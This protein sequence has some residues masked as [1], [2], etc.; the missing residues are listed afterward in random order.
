MNPQRPN[1]SGS[2]AQGLLALGSL[3]LA[4]GI[5]VWQQ[6]VL[7]RGRTMPIAGA[8]RPT[9]TFADVAGLIEAKE[10]LA[11]I[12]SFLRDPDRFAR[13]G[14]RMPRGVLLAGPP[15]TG[16]TLLARAVAGEARV[17]FFAMSASQ[18]V[19][20]Y[21]GVGA[22]RVRDLF[23]A[24]RKAA[25]AIVFVDELDAIGRRRGDSQ[26]HQEYEQ[27]LNQ[28]LVELDGFHPRQ[29]VVLI[30]ATNRSEILDPALLRPGRFD[31]RVDLNL[32]DRAERAA[33]LKVH[34][35]GKPLDPRVDL[36]GLASRTVGLSG[37]DLEN[38]VNEAALLAV[39]RDGETIHQDD[40]EEAVARVVAGPT[41]RSRTLSER[42][43]NTIAVHEAGH[44]LVA[45]RLSEADAPRRVT[46]LGRGQMG[47]ATMLAPEEDR[48]LWTRGQFLHRLAVLLGG[49]AAEEHRFQEVTTGSSNDLTQ[50]IALART[51]ITGYG[52]GQRLRGLAFGQDTL[53]SEET[54]RAIDDEVKTLVSD[55]LDLAGRTIS[56]DNGT[57]DRLVTALLA[58]ET[59]DENRLAAI[60]GARPSTIVD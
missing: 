54:S 50:A 11:E 41:R 38:T 2:L 36:D 33:I 42:E 35:E 45:H 9:T 4:V 59:L 37:A 40:L 31:R 25:P 51:M 57:L 53:L 43:R 10:E 46:I 20:V 60:L 24:A 8:E 27:T 47:G 29:A 7:N 56:A 30:G 26:S 6:R 39:R 12:V 22:K 13:M 52:M 1:Q 16:K 5:A 28:F 14:A 21:V 44:A 55:A 18:F 34:A 17:P 58:E 48:Q 49:Y 19:E 3:G 23:A 15:G 32:P